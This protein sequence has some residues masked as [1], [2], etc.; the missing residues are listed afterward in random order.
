M[1]CGGVFA[2]VIEYIVNLIYQ[3]MKAIQS[4]VYAFSGM[5]IFAK[6]TASSMKNTAGSAKQASKS[7]AGVHN[8]INNVSE[9]SASGGSGSVGPSINLSQMDMQMN[10]WIGSV[11][12]KFIELFQP[13]QNSWNQYGQSLIESIKY[14]FKSHLELIKSIGKSFKE[15]WLNE[16]GEHTINTILQIL[17]SM[18]NICG[19]IDEAFKKAWENNNGTVVIQNI[20]NAFNNILDVISIVM[21]SL[22]KWTM[23]ESFQNFTNSIIEICN[24]LSY[25]F[26]LITQK[27]KEVWEN[28]GSNTFT[29]LL[30]IISKIVQV[31]SI[32]LQILTPIIEYILNVTTPIIS[33]IIQLIGFLLDAIGG[34][35][36]FIIGIFSGSWEIAWNGIK[37]VFEGIWNAIKTIL[38]IILSFIVQLWLHVWEGIK[39]VAITVWN[40]IIAI[41][42]NVLNG[43]KNTISNVLN[44]IKT[45]WT[46]IWTGLKNT[47]TNV[48]NGIWNCIKGV[49]NLILGGIEN[50]VNGTIRGINKLLSGISN[51]ANAVGSIVGLNPINLQL[52]TIS[53][54]RLAKGGIINNPTI[55][56]MGEYSGA[57]SNPEIVA[58]QNILRETFDEVLSNHEWD[59]NSNKPIYL[60]VNV[61]NKRLGDILLENLND[62]KRRTG[63]NLEAL[64]GG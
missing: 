48:W 47:V 55:A 44:A 21:E 16:T 60:T 28:A 4:V 58:P 18:F 8:E 45:V 5:N 22:E 14:A 2:P 51:V 32:V 64:V 54:P 17:T 3:L 9:N 46:N 19:N 43:I 27:I 62:K 34:I 12:K 36:D 15:I 50:F 38:E 13:I 31:I 53:L 20:W 41:I 49:I 29:K 35:L 26:Q 30:E 25:W 56:L 52:S 42:S 59:N 57:R 37:E 1:L 63:K 39:N 33:G 6:A 7:L 24:I 11:Q 23:S 40:V 10:D 61:G